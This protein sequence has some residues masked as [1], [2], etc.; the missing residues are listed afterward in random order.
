VEKKVSGSLREVIED[1]LNECTDCA[2]LV[3][4]FSVVWEALPEGERIQTPASLWQDLLDKIQSH[5]RP[6][7]IDKSVFDGFVRLM[8]PVVS[9][10]LLLLAMFFGFHLGNIPEG[11]PE[12]AGPVEADPYLLEEVFV[13]EYFQDFQDF[14]LGS[15]GDVYVSLEIPDMDEES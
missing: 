11:L 2:R 15:I 9:V 14:P 6:L 5:D 4:R 13:T 10:S 1:H 12:T 3:G 8:R 7:S